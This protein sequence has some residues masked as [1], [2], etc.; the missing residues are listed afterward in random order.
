[1]NCVVCGR[2]RPV[3][4]VTCGGSFCQE[5]SYY[6]NVERVARRG[7]RARTDAAGRAATAEDAARALRVGREA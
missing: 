1:M 2:V 3:G 7:S 4:F 5:A 6:R